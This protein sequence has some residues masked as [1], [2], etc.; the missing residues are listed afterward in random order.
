MFTTK[1][2]IGH[3]FTARQCRIS[4]CVLPYRFFGGGKGGGWELVKVLEINESCFSWLKCNCGR[5]YH[6]VGLCWV[7]QESGRPVLHL[8]LNASPRRCLS[9]LRRVLD[10]IAYCSLALFMTNST[11]NP[12]CAN[13][14]SGN[15]YVY[16]YILPGTTIVSDCW[17]TN[18]HLGNEGPTEHTIEQCVSFVVSWKGTHTNK[19]E[20]TW[21]HAYFTSGL[22]EKTRLN[23]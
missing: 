2:L 9:S 13:N 15:D 14:G 10:S 20:A 3:S 19:I 7:E 23:L 17:G 4:F 16:V 11:F 12:T 21:K 22:S 18:I 6:R 8:W 1:L 5:L